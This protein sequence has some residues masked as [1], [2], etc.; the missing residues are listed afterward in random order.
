[1]VLRIHLPEYDVT[2]DQQF[3][4]LCMQEPTGCEVTNLILTPAST[5][6]TNF[7]YDIQDPP[8]LVK[9]PLPHAAY[10]P[11]ACVY[12][13]IF[14]AE[15]LGGGDLPS[16]L[17]F[18]PQKGF[19]IFT[20]NPAHFGTLQVQLN[21]AVNGPSTVGTKVLIYTVELSRCKID[22]LEATSIADIT[23]YIGRGPL[24]VESGVTNQFEECNSEIT[25][26]L[27]RNN[28]ETLDDIFTVDQADRSF[29]IATDDKDLD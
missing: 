5:P 4:A 23:Y 17:A 16:Y 8:E 29:T 2:H 25:M 13:L 1:M 27:T 15:L 11:A 9:I 28:G 3:A 26:K 7:V 6:G 19:E 10:E 24:K 22:Q 14:E 18:D 21:V 12:D 20:N